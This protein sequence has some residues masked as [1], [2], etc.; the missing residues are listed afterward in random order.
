MILS[1]FYFITA[2]LAAPFQAKVAIAVSEA[3]APA[4]SV[5]S[6]FTLFQ[7][8]HVHIRN[9][10]TQLNCTLS[11]LDVGGCPLTEIQACLCTNDTL[12]YELSLCVLNSCDRA[13]QIG[14][15]YQQSFWVS[16]RLTPS[17][18]SRYKYPPEWN[19]CGSSVSIPKSIHHS[20]RN[21]PSCFHVSHHNSTVDLKAMGGSQGL[22]GWL[23]GDNCSSGYLTWS[24][25]LSQAPLTP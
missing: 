8:F 13:D 20:S 17:D 10:Q 21:H 18:L 2:L 23:D 9:W 25:V 3:A 7:L 16:A 19:L 12:Q 6:S 5:S 1:N 22:V 15:F 4:C 14:Y 24:H 11:V